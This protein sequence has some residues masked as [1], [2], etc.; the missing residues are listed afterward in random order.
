MGVAEV[1]KIT[2]TNNQWVFRLNRL[3]ASPCVRIG[4]NI[5]FRTKNIALLQAYPKDARI[6]L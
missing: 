6:V 1:F 4:L 2:L 5:P 3:V